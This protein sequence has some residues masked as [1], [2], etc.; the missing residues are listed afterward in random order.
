MEGKKMFNYE[1]SGNNDAKK[2][3]DMQETMVKILQVIIG[4]IMAVLHM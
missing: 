4:F 3:K 1:A 2:G